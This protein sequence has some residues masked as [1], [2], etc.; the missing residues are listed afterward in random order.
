MTPPLPGL[1]MKAV[2]PPGGVSSPMVD[3]LIASLR[4]SLLGDGD[5][6]DKASAPH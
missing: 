1:V 4:G 6:G 3:D 5:G 2:L